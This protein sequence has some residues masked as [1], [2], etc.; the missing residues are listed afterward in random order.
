MKE[1]QANVVVFGTCA[2]TQ[3]IIYRV[4][5]L[6][7]YQLLWQFTH[8]TYILHRF[9]TFILMSPPLYCVWC[10]LPYFPIMN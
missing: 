10:C 9:W 1:V 6:L 8:S 4:G 2:Q 7:W 5:L 3:D